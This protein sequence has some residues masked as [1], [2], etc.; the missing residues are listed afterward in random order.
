MGDPGVMVTVDVGV[1]LPPPVVARTIP[2]TAP[3]TPAIIAILTHL[4]EY[5]LPCLAR[6]LPFL[7]SSA[8]LVAF[9]IET[10]VSPS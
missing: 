4:E 2:V 7:P 6:L 9:V 3:A 1:E 8:T 10:L 5:Q